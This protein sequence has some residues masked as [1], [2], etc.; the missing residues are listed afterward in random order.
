MLAVKRSAGIAPEVNLGNQLHTGEEA[1]TLTLKAKADITRSP[2]Q[3]YQRPHKKDGCP[4]K[5][6]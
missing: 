5:I 3:E 4:P 6:K 1:S 2:K